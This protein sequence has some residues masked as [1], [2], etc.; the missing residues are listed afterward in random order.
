M[1]GDTAAKR[2]GPRRS[3]QHNRRRLSGLEAKL[4]G[5]SEE[6]HTGI[7][8]ERTCQLVRL[9]TLID[10]CQMKGQASADAD[11]CGHKPV[12]LNSHADGLFASLAGSH[13]G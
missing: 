3:L 10:D 8:E 9:A 1:A 2:V 13:R 12:V 7:L 4:S 6:T 5:S 11:G